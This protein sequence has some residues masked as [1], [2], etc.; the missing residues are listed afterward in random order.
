[1]PLVSLGAMAILAS[2][3]VL[4]AAPVPPGPLVPAVSRVM[5][6][7]P[8]VVDTD[9][10][11]LALAVKVLATFELITTVHWPLASVTFGAPQLSVTAP[12]IGLRVTTGLTPA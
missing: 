8:L 11:I 9:N 6:T 1:M 5:V 3:K 4:V 10:V 2:T 12:G 7:S